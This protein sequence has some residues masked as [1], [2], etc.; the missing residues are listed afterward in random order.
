[1]TL[2]TLPNKIL[3]NSHHTVLVMRDGGTCQA[4]CVVND[5]R[6][7]DVCSELGLIESIA[8]SKLDHGEVAFDGRVWI[9]HSDM[10]RPLHASRH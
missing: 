2:V 5:G 3:R 1:M 8:S 10:P 6:I 9:T 4:V 7:G